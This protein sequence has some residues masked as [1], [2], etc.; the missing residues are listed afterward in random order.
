MEPLWSVDGEEALA[1]L[2]DAGVSE[3]AAENVRI[4]MTE[5]CTERLQHFISRLEQV[6]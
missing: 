4:T 5:L 2:L 6:L 1:A 3:Q